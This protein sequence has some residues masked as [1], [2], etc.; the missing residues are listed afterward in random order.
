MS[1]HYLF[2]SVSASGHLNP[3]LPLVRELVDRGHRV[4]YV[5]D[6]K[7]RVEVEAAGAT[8]VPTVWGGVD[9]GGALTFGPEMVLG[10]IRHLIA[11]TR[12]SYP[13]LM[14]RFE[15]DR[16]DA[17]C[18]DI[19]TLLGR[20]LAE[21]LAVPDITLV[22]VFAAN[23]HFSLFNRMLPVVDEATREQ[24]MAELGE[25]ATELGLAALPHPVAGPPS[26]RT[27]VFIPRE[28]QP[29]G[30]TFDDRFRFVGPLVGQ[31]PDRGDWQPPTQGRPLLFISLGTVFNNRPDFFQMC[32]AAFGD[33]KW[34][35]AM[36]TGGV[37]PAL[38]GDLPANFDVRP[39]FP[40]TLV[41]QHADAFLSHTG[42]NSTMESLLYGV[43]L[44]AVPQQPEQQANAERVEELGLGRRLVTDDITATM[45]RTAV[46]D[47]AADRGIRTRLDEMQAIIAKAGGA[48]EAA[49]LVEAR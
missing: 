8:L 38:L 14:E 17:V 49:D 5:T 24:M 19:S 28:F 7:R 27:I 48:V 34:Q 13:V 44:V 10:R 45:L 30:D 39:T 20:V 31:R 25:L 32:V 1:K 36:A 37:D 42:M 29:A 18:F 21:K 41:L 35:V 22:P 2:T 11:E 4:S 40:Q 6:A 16:P 46:D 12:A 9:A 3:T 43:P 33:G 47:V 15:R 23:E 26:D